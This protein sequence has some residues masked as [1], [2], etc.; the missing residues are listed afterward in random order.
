MNLCGAIA[1]VGQGDQLLLEIPDE[2]FQLTPRQDA[3][4]SVPSR[5][6]SASFSKIGSSRRTHYSRP[7]STPGKS[8]T[9]VQSPTLLNP[10]SKDDLKKSMG[11]Q[12][13][14]AQPIV[15]S[16]GS[17]SAIKTLQ[18][19]F[20]VVSML[21]V[22]FFIAQHPASSVSLCFVYFFHR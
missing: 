20:K 8:H 1:N 21:M 15:L 6:N 3:S 11:R 14:D 7:L 4:S 22:E 18:A 13:S 16:M 2:K 19:G 9:P 12:R 10:I 17:S 5:R